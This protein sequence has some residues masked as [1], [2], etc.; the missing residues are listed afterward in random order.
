MSCVSAMT[1]DFIT[2]SPGDSVA[3]VLQDFK[4]SKTEYAPVLD[5]SGKPAGIF[6]LQSLMKNLLPVSVA[7]SGGVSLDIQIPAAPG[8]AKRLNKVHT[9][10][11]GDVMDRSVNSVARETPVWEAVNMLVQHGA[12]L[13]VTEQN[14]KA[15][16]MITMQSALD[17]LNKM[18]DSEQ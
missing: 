3:K 12:P 10:T 15:I 4:K 16:G 11:V 6:S 18:K 5:A 9:L 13:L 14:G 7:V 1:K 8:V 2:V 17:E